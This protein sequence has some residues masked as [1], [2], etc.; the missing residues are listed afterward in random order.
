MGRASVAMTAL[1]IS[2]DRDRVQ[3]RYYR[4]AGEHVAVFIPYCVIYCQVYNSVLSQL[5]LERK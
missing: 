4:I 5:Q 2:K 3:I 1:F